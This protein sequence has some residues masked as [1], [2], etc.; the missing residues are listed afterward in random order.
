MIS[1]HNPFQIWES[2]LPYNPNDFCL[3][4]TLMLYI[5]LCLEFKL[6]EAMYITIY[7]T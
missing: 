5:P 6:F 1:G 2:L 3:D 4:L 7:V